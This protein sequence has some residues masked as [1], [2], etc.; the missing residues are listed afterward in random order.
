VTT[1]PKTPAQPQIPRQAGTPPSPDL[2]PD[3][4]DKDPIEK[5]GP[6][7]DP[8]PECWPRHPETVIVVFDY[9]D[10]QPGHPLSLD[11]ILRASLTRSRDPEPDLEAEP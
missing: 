10:G 2:E 11:G 5:G 7:D 4:D 1:S 9:R 6:L 3:G 8:F